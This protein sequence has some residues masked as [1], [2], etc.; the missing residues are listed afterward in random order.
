MILDIIL[1][2]LKVLYNTTYYML[3]ITY[4]SLTLKEFVTQLMT[5]LLYIILLNT[6]LVTKEISNLTQNVD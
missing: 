2:N 1:Y 6:W 5:N 3:Y 4:K